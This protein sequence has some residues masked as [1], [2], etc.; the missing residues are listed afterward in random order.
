MAGMNSTGVRN[1][2]RVL[3]L[4]M[5]LAAVV[6]AGFVGARAATGSRMQ[7]PKTPIIAVVDLEEVINNLKEREDRAEVIKAKAR[8]ADERLKPIEDRVKSLAQQLES[9]PTGTPE[10]ARKQDE[11]KEVMFR[12]EFERQLALKVINEMGINMFRD[13]YL[14]VDNAAER[15]AKKNGYDV[16]LVSDEKAEIPSGDNEA[17][18]KRAMLM[19]RMLFV[20]PQLDITREVIQTMNNEYAAGP[21]AR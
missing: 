8:E 4:A 3:T 10:R 11:V 5:L 20:N 18:L 6:V 15:I 16:V 1:G 12:G 7:A 21:K 19:K 13:L 2:S 9:L 17:A 14:K